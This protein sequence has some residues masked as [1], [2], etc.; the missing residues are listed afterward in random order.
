MHNTTQHYTNYITLHYIYNCNY[1]YNYHYIALRYTTLITI[2]YN[3]NYTT[4]HY[5]RL[6]YTI[7]HYNT[8]VHNATVY[9][10]LQYTTIYYTNYATPQLQ[11][12]LQLHFTNYITLEQLSTTTPLHYSTTTTTTALRHTTSNS[13]GEVTPATIATTPKNTTPPFG[14]SVDSLCHPWFTTTNLSCFLFLKLPPPPCAVIL[15]RKPAG[16]AG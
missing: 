11:L 12:Q 10:T 16:Q 8:T 9:S 14:P 7:P 15:A 3:Y 2:H 1:N 4:L 13:C 6:H 5:T